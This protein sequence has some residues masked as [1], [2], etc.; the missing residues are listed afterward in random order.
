[1]MVWRQTLRSLGSLRTGSSYRRKWLDAESRNWSFSSAAADKSAHKGIGRGRLRCRISRVTNSPTPVLTIASALREARRRRR[2][3]IAELAAS[4]GPM[5]VIL[6]AQI[7]LVW[8]FVRWVTFPLMGKDYDAAVIVAGHC[9]FAHGATPNAVANM[10]SICRSFSPS[11]RAFL[12]VP[13]VGGM[14]ID[15]TNSLNITWFL[16]LLK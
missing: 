3:T 12:I 11:Q 2:M 8:A 9:G 5:L 4:A 6:S 10:D 14:L 1:M 16:N 13:I 7:L 15:L